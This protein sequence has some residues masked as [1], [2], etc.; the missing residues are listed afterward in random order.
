[1]CIRTKPQ[2]YYSTTEGTEETKLYSNSH[3][4]L[5]AD[6]EKSGLFICLALL[7]HGNQSGIIKTLF[8]VILF[9]RM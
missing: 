8:F 9:N 1:M 3:T 5:V 6:V 7:L 4:V 2:I